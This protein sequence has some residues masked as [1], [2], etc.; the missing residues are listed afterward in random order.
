MHI[1]FEP[2]T[3]N[4]FLISRLIPDFDIISGLT[5]PNSFLI[6][7]ISDFDKAV[8]GLRYRSRSLCP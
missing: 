5:T 1:I 8:P 3:Q 7:L 2:G 6:S 4:P